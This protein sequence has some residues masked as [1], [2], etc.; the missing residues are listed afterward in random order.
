MESYSL[1]VPFNFFCEFFLQMNLSPILFLGV[2]SGDLERQ[3]T[4][5]LI[6]ELFFLVDRILIK[7]LELHNIRNIH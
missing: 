3:E 2:S 4:T 5:P 1:S 7:K 6:R